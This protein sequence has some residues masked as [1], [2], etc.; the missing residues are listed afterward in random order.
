[1]RVM[2]N[3]IHE[4]GLDEE[5]EDRLIDETGNTNF[6]LGQDVDLDEPSDEEDPEQQLR[7]EAA[8]RR[9][10]AQAVQGALEC[11]GVLLDMERARME[12]EDLKSRQ[13]LR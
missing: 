6:W 8:D 12:L 5:L 4:N 10:M 13:L 3:V 1:M 11:R 9:A 7:A 2:D